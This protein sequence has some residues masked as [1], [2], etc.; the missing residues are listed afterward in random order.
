[1]RRMLTLALLVL[2]VAP[3]TYAGTTVS[4]PS[5]PGDGSGYLA[6]RLVTDPTTIANIHAPILGNFGGKDRGIPP[7]AGNKEGYVA[8]DAADA[9]KRI[10]PFFAAKL[11]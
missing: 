10:D 7:A 9:W 1:M 5:K 6:L 3:A 4:F 11:R 8:E 2:A